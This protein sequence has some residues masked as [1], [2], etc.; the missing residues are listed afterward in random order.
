M[1][2]QTSLNFCLGNG[3]L[4]DVRQQT[5]TWTN[6]DLSFISLISHLL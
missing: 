4:S 6:V 2:W 1:A 3:L 5:I